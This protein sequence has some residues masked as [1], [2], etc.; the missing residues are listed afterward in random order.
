MAKSPFDYWKDL[1]QLKA[2]L[3]EESGYSPYMMTRF[4]S[5]MN[6]TLQ[7]AEEI[8]HYDLPK[9]V[10]YNLLS[11][12]LPKRYMKFDYLKKKKDEKDFKFVA[13][14]FEFGSR[15][16]KLALAIMSDDEVNTIKKKYGGL[17]R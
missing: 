2:P 5:M 8:S 13:K 9:E 7:Y 16:L 11:S 6:I 17:E 14:Y 1:T 4:L 3:E 12:F 15:D 10:H